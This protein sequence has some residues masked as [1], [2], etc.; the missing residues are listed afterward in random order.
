[1]TTRPQQPDIPALLHAPGA[2]VAVVGATDDPTKYG[3]RIYRDLKSKGFTVYA[4]NPNRDTV[5][6]DPAWPS[7]AAL[8]EAPTIVDFVVPPPVTLRLL[9]EAKELGYTDVWIQPGAEDDAVIA[10]L[11]AEGFNSL[12][13]ACIMVQA[14]PVP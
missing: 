7:L 13:N 12:V 10:Y 1:M 4:V 8:P 14:R 3:G 2:T 5:D 6:G 11:D 9:E